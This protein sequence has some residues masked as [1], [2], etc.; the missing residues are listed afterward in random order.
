MSEKYLIATSEQPIAAYHVDDWVDPRTLP[1][2][3]VG[4]STCFRKEVGVDRQDMLQ[5]SAV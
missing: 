3:Y 1:R 5:S 2:K 4:Y